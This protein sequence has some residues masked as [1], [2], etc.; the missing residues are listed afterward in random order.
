MARLK[1]AIAQEKESGERVATL[2]DLWSESRLMRKEFPVCPP[3]LAISVR[4]RL[5]V[6]QYL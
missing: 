2:F 1:H 6:M 3:M 4:G 5:S